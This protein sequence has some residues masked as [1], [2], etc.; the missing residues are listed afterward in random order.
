MPEPSTVPRPAPRRRVA[1]VSLGCAKNLVDSEVMAGYLRRSGFEFAPRPER[2]DVTLINTCGFIAPAREEAEAEIAKAVAWKRKRAGRRLVVVGCYV[3]RDP[4]A[5]RRRFP[6]VDAWSG[7][8]GFDRIAGL[9][10]GAGAGE[11]RRTFLY[12]DETPRIVTTPRGWAYIKISEGC[13]RRCSFCAIPSI[14]GP[15]R[16]RPAA[17]I[18]REARNLASLGVVEINIISHD[19]T[20]YGRDRGEKDGLPKLLRRL[21]R[22]DGLARIRVLYGYPEGVTPALLDILEHERMC[23]Y[24][25]LPFQHA[26]PR[27]VRAM[28]RSMD[29]ERGLRLLEKIRQRLPDVALR[30]SVIV[31]FPGETEAEFRALLEFVREARFDHLGAFAY[32]PEE[33]TSAARLPG[34]IDARTME[35]RRREVMTLQAGISL[36]HNRAR[37]GTVVETLIEGA[38]PMAGHS[39][40]PPSSSAAP[41][42]GHSVP[43]PSSSAAGRPKLW[44][45]RGRFQAPDV[46]GVILVPAPRRSEA[47]SL[48]GTLRDVEITAAHQYDCRGRIL[49]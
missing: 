5:L 49:P 44:Y 9:I 27:L 47:A 38:A 15:Y 33:G 24:L 37:V 34:R 46:D 2:A 21:V 10:E 32:S 7:V 48:A 16:S 20:A 13:S 12:G 22:V 28:G 18:G 41:M 39:V 23:R 30:T 43:P 6:E 3:E 31:G 25:D 45:G 11:G 26:A 1:M 8:K 42:A 29:G 40:P 14:K 35:E 36:A 4:E 19:S 17:S